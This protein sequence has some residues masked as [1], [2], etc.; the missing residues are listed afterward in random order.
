VLSLSRKSWPR[1]GSLTFHDAGFKHVTWFFTSAVDLATLPNDSHIQR[2]HESRA[3]DF[4]S[5]NRNS[6]RFY[7]PP[8]QG[9]KRTHIALLRASYV[10]ITPPTIEDDPNFY[11]ENYLYYPSAPRLLES[12]VKLRDDVLDK[13]GDV[14]CHKLVQPENTSF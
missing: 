8:G 12:N 7:F 1:I 9:P 4:A 14:G 6:V 2:I 10:G 5:L 13:C 11:A 3:K